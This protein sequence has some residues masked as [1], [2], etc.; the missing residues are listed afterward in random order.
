MFITEG[1]FSSSLDSG[2]RFQFPASLRQLSAQAEGR[3]V[4]NMGLEKCITLYP[5]DE[6]QLYRQQ[7]SQL[8]VFR[9][10]QRALVRFFLSSATEVKVDSKNRILIPKHLVQYASLEKDLLIVGMMH[11]FEIWNPTLYAEDM[12]QI[13]TR[14]SAAVYDLAERIHTDLRKGGDR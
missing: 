5:M 11:F 2:G 14:E 7:L 9:P 4:M 8:N 10:D 6:W 13:P 3:F 1:T 12:L